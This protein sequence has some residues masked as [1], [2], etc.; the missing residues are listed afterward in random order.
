MVSNINE[1]LPEIRSRTNTEE[2]NIE[3]TC[4]ED[5]PSPSLLS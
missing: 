5:R 1:R 2:Y 3:E 4:T